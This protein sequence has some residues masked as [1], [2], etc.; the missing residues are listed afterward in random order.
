MS[1]APS[2]QLA[3]KVAVIT[4]ASRGIGEA[5]ARAFAREGATVVL[6]SR[7]QSD[8]DS[9]A[10][11][12]EEA[13]GR[14]LAIACHAGEKDALESLFARVVDELGR[15]DVL[16]N[17]AATNPYFG[18]ALEAPEWAFDKTFAVNAKGYF[19]ACQCAGH[20]M[21]EQGGGAIINIASILGQKPAP[22][23]VIYAMTKAAVISMT[24]GLAQELGPQGVRVN[25]IAPGLVET[26]FASA[27]IE[28]D[29]LHRGFVAQTPLRRHGQPEEIAGA[30]VY[31][32][33]DASSFATGS[34]LVVDGG[35]T[36]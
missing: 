14:A 20:H 6:A 15:V 32:A 3:D 31:L 19:L 17:N 22:L 34:V 12:I 5:I 8:L 35:F 11:S 10:R 2:A 33:S 1:E 29:K 21:V 9:V 4:G 25:A 30:A 27:L 23:Q 26:R 36:A 7:T 16:V 28:D 24:K 18:M 13:G